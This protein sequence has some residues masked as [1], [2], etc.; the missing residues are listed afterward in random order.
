MP[1]V[2]APA[3]D[4]RGGAEPKLE[5]E[6]FVVR[7]AP[8]E[9]ADLEAY[10]AAINVGVSTLLRR[11]TVAAV[12]A[13][14]HSGLTVGQLVGGAADAIGRDF[15][16]TFGVVERTPWRAR[17]AESVLRWLLLRCTVIAPDAGGTA[18]GDG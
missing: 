2:I 7:L 3:R 18:V 8:D 9:L 4:T 1:E 15:P 12:R 13:T 6:A 14:A 17:L 11:T 16:A 5:L 10:A